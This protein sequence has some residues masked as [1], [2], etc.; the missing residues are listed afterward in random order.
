MSELAFVCV[1][2]ATTRL[3]LNQGGIQRVWA[4]VFGLPPRKKGIQSIVPKRRPLW[5]TCCCS[6]SSP[7]LLLSSRTCIHKGSFFQR[8]SHRLKFFFPF[9][10]CT[11][12][13]YVDRLTY[14]AHTHVL[15]ERERERGCVRPAPEA[16]FINDGS[17][18][19]HRHHHHVV[20]VAALPL[21]LYYTY[22]VYQARE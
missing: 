10:M 4:G 5:F 13:C 6:P 17:E 9:H 20:V 19:P 14:C 18:R 22:T 2:E 8:E 1:F 11:Y 7:S 15:G 16:T 12:T 21:T 3:V